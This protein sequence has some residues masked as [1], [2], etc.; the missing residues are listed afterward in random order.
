MIMESNPFE[1]KLDPTALDS[2]ERI[3]EYCRQNGFVVGGRTRIEDVISANPDLELVYEDLGE[4]DAYIMKLPHKGYKIAVNS[5]H[6]KRR[7]RFSM[8]HEYVHYQLHRDRIGN[9]PEGEQILFR[10]SERNPIEYQANQVAGKIL[11]PKEE[12][13][14]CIKQKKGNINSIAE[15]FDV[16]PEAV[17]VRAS[18]LG[19]ISN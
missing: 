15:F 10:D 1:I 6:H 12:F 19:W 11:M 7:Q 14:E 4:S 16:S 5:R 8:T 9:K 3:L 17:R 13:I 18:Q 2:P